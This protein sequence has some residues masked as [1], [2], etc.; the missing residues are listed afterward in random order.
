MTCCN[1]LTRTTIRSEE[2]KKSLM[3]RLSRMEG[4]I[5]GLKK[6][7]ESDMFCTDIITQTEAIDAALKAFNKTLLAN[8][9]RNCVVN[10]IKTGD[11]DIINETVDDLVVTVQNLMK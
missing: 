1:K 7:I 11:E 3:N 8:H 10:N 9:I 5:R 2:E 4:Q 6:M